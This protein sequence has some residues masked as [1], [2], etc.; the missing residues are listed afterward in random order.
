MRK[1]NPDKSLMPDFNVLQPQLPID[2]PIAQYVRQSSMGQVKK[3][4][5]SQIQQD[6]MF[7]KRLVKYGWKD[8]PESIILIDKDLGISG[9]KKQDKREGLQE[10]FTLIETG[11]IGAIAAFDA[12][13][14]WRDRT[15][16]F[17]NHFIQFLKEHDIP[18][19]MFNA[20]YF[21]QRPSD[22][23]ALREEFRQ[24]AYQLK[25]VYEKMNQ[26][27]YKP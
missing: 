16:E 22:E 6:A 7:R 26:Q 3:N 18:V 25:H 12:S 11:K 8:T 10:L 9:Q 17:Y 2:K 23:E 4:I 14:L 13:R 20:V 5:Q 19:I 15:H 24:A 21:L 1:I 27:S